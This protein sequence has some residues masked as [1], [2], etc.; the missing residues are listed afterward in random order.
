MDRYE[1][2]TIL[3]TMVDEDSAIIQYRRDTRGLL[4]ADVIVNLLA[5]LCSEK[6]SQRQRC[7]MAETIKSRSQ[8]SL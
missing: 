6:S 7:D 2:I 5:S 3:T 1:T 8:S 4:S